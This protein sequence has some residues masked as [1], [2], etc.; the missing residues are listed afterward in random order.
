M[1]PWANV[2]LETASTV[3]LTAVG[4]HVYS[5]HP[6]T[7]VLCMA[8]KVNGGS[9][10]LWW[11]WMP[12][13]EELNEVIRQG[14][15]IHAWNA[16]FERIMWPHMVAHGARPID[17]DQ[18][19]CT[20]VRALLMGFPG[21]LEHAGPSMGLG[22]C[23]DDA[24][25][26]IMLQLC[27]PRQRWTPGKKGYDEA[28]VRTG[29]LHEQTGE[30]QLL[31]DGEVVRWWQDEAKLKRL[32]EYCLTDVDTEAAAGD[33]LDPLPD[34]ELQG[35]MLDQQINDRGFYVD[36]KLVQAALALVKP[37]TERANEKLIKLTDGELRSVT[38]PNLIRAW[39]NRELGLELD[40]INKKVLN[41]IL[42][43]MKDVLPKHVKEVIKLRLAA[44]KTSTAKLRALTKGLNQDGR[45]RGGLQYAGA[46]RT[47]RWS[48]RRFQ[49]QNLPRP[50]KWA[51]EAVREVL[52][53]VLDSI[54]ILYGSGL[55]AISNIIRSCIVAAP[56]NELHFADYNAI[57]ARITAWF[58][59]ATKILEAYRT[60]KDPYRMMAAKVFDIEDWTTISKDGFERFLGKQ[61]ILGAGFGMGPPRFQ[62]QCRDYG[63]YIELDLA[64]RSIYTYRDDNWEIP[65]GWKDLERAATLAMHA[66]ASDRWT[67]ALGGKVHFWY[68]GSTFLRVLLPSGRTLSYLHP[69]LEPGE[70]PF[71]KPCVRFK[72]WGWNNERQRM[73]WQD[74]YG[75]KWM[76]NIVQ[77]TARDVML[78]AML[79]LVVS[80]W[81]LILTVHDE[82]GAE[83]PIGEKLKDDLFRTMAIPPAWAPDLPLHVEGWTGQRYRK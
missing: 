57:E 47:N 3:D 4:A 63:Q 31:P 17:L 41:D 15:E 77:A 28:Y 37:A 46:G 62:G 72:F 7:H 21:K 24:G 79:R 27:K 48:G 78:D 25:H 61:I 67:P 16:G 59:G 82:V 11:P 75:G 45:F 83:H 69:R 38:Q 81:C 29:S 1:R 54:E 64:Q 5:E 18:W 56:G 40:S 51:L 9:T 14:G 43:T 73:E 68:D 23:K 32:G 70:T 26:R 33:F 10:R 44:A 66:P 39:I 19:R 53:G 42:V 13:P 22:V 8:W 55:E 12:F 36:T 71:G 74:M 49:P 6:T 35:W 52:E 50:E 2:D 34:R 65:E 80:G 58:C 20:M 76:E 60:G 30:Y